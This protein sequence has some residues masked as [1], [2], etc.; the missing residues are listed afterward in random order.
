MISP[1]FHDDIRPKTGLSLVK[2]PAEPQDIATHFSFIILAT[3]DP[4]IQNTF[5]ECCRNKGLFFCRCDNP[6]ASDF[7]IGS[8]LHEEPLTISFIASGSP[9]IAKLVGKR[10]E[11]AIDPAL[12][13]LALIMNALRP[14][15]K[16]KFQDEAERK[17]FFQ[18]WTSEETVARLREI[19]HEGLLKEI[20]ACL[21]A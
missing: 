3:N 2:R 20:L 9:G 1:E 18:Q 14:T 8:I 12:S 5:A 4:V 11:G 17:A 10:I 16:E 19:G 6:E 15:I 7:F 21:S 13:Q